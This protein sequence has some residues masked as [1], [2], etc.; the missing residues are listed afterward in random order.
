MNTSTA[1]TG[2]P[3]ERFDAVIVGSG[4]NGL[5]AA[6]TLANAGKRVLV[7]EK[8]DAFGGA[9][10]TTDHGKPEWA[11]DVGSTVHALA[12]ISPAHRQLALTG[13]EYIDPPILLSHVLDG[14][15]GASMYR[16]VEQTA[17]GLGRDAA[18]YRRLIEPMV[19]RFDDLAGDILRPLISWP[20]HPLLLARFGLRAL[21]PMSTMA[22]LFRTEEARALLGGS[23]AHSFTPLHH[24]LTTSFAVM[25]HASGH[26]AGW[27]FARG[28]S[29][30][31][32][33]ALAAVVID[34]GGT[35]LTGHEVTSI[36]SLPDHDVLL[37]DT[38][39]AMAAGLIA[40]QLPK[41]RQ[42]RYRK[43]RHGPGAF[44]IDFEL[45]EA[46]PWEYEQA[47]QA[48]TVHVIGDY[49]ELAASERSIARGSLPERPFVLFCQATVADPSRAPV[50][51]HTG[52]AYAHVPHGFSG[53]ASS[54][55]VS[56]IERFAPGFS[57]LIETSHVS[58]PA[59]LESRNPNLVGG[60]VGGGSYSGL[61]I[62]RR[63]VLSPHPY[64]TGVRGVYLCSAST[65]PGAG[66]HGMSGYLAAKDALGRELA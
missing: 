8:A 9:A 55:I 48:G 54:A 30:S 15:N 45:S 65:P 53:D 12:A 16:S 21:P 6:A 29:Q 42:R 37:L 49:G 44:K 3:N 56:Q 2:L 39:P 57:D 31:L 35:I 11:H 13:V 20:S 23:A 36:D 18:R 10:S 5:T 43:F 24:P 51:K 50:G 4:P 66:A 33:N 1:A 25:L 14:G 59:Q 52:W 34:S 62:L 40:D 22:R 32:S 19:R 27:P 41:S 58:S 38:N 63:P 17:A 26:H 64:R 7:L 61:Q 47:R 28:G 46:V 60:D